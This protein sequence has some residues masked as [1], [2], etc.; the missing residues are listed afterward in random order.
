MLK[1]ITAVKKIIP[2]FKIY[3]WKASSII[4]LGLLSSVT[5]VLGISLLIPF[6][7]T[8]SPTTTNKPTIN[9]SFLDFLNF[10]FSGVS[11]DLRPLIITLCIVLSVF[12]KAGFVYS[13]TVLIHWLYAHLLDNLRRRIFQ[14]LMN[15]SQS[16]WDTNQCGK[17]LGTIGG[18]TSNAC[19][20]LMQFLWLTINIC[21][22]ITYTMMLL[23]LSW[24]LTLLVIFTL[25]I[26]SALV[27]RMTRQSERLGEQNLQVSQELN[28]I[29]V[30]LL[31]GIKT[32]RSF[33]REFH[34]QERFNQASQNVREISIELQQLSAIV[35][36]LFEVLA[37]VLLVVVMFIALTTNTT[38]PILLT[39]IFMLYR[40]QP[41]V[42][43]FDVNRTYLIALSSSITDVM[44]LLDTFD[45]PYIHSGHI[46]FRKL[47]QGIWLK[48]VSFYYSNQDKP[49]LD[50]VSIYIPQG[51]TTAFVGSS[52]AGKSTLVNLICRFYDVTQ[53]KIYVDNYYLPDLDL[54]SWRSKIALVSQDIHLFNTTVGENIAYGRLGATNDDVIQAAK[55]ANAH[56]FIL[57]L[58][59]GYDTFVGDRGVLLSGGQKQRISIARAIICNPEILIMD[60]ATNALDS[61]SENFIQQSISNLS[62]NRTVIVIAHRLSTIETADQIIVLKEGKVREIGNFDV[63]LS[64]NGLFAQ[65][66]KLQYGHNFDQ[67]NV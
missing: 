10:I 18:Q 66:Y 48:S 63:L 15:V 36:L 11:A 64:K 32:I 26:I 29:M 1:D 67:D 40:L 6:L 45:K 8:L 52:G 3:P 35:E 27:R 31:T 38:L 49:A 9:N 20:G 60:E 7:D 47:E 16:F 5:E 57:N 28:N 51:K 12:I 59:Q 41:Q 50:D 13:Y 24:K 14:Q 25:G 54:S 19:A 30:E 21:V 62:K 42:K 43:N 2:L 33:G 37:V 17:L 44:S 61:V 55:L 56:D 22:A 46:Q 39:F 53:G 4:I 65:L 23:F 58:P 34:E